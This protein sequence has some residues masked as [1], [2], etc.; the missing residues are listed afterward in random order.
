MSVQEGPLVLTFGVLFPSI[1]WPDLPSG[2][3]PLVQA[4]HLPAPLSSQL[5]LLLASLQPLNTLGVSVPSFVLGPREKGMETMVRSAR[6]KGLPS[7]PGITEAPSITGASLL[8]SPPA[9]NIKPRGTWGS[10]SGLADRGE[11]HTCLSW[12]QERRHK[13]AEQDQ[14]P[15]GDCQE[16]PAAPR[17]YL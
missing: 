16:S 8:P 7:T 2:S 3:Q 14:R 10:L 15:H 9:V 11:G 12:E 13:A 6:S 5:P 4:S 1:Y 17:L